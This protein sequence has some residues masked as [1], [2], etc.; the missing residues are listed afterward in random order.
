MN[1]IQPMLLKNYYISITTKMQ[2]L[3]ELIRK[4]VK[5]T[6]NDLEL[7]QKLRYLVFYEDKLNSV[8]I[9]KIKRIKNEIKGKRNRN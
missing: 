9:S 7:G 8:R 2:G 6:P 1:F 5:Q 4:L 3:T